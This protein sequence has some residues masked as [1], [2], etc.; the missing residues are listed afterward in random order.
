V[1]AQINNLNVQA[2]IAQ[3]KLLIGKEQ[4]Q[5]AQVKLKLEK[6]IR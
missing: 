2:Q 3:P 1:G 6:R 4:V 5:I